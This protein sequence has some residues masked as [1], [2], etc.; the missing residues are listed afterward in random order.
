MRT[1]PGAAPTTRS[2]RVW[3]A[4]TRAFH[5][6]LAA[7]F[8]GAWLLSE[9]ERFRNLHIGFGYARV[10]LIAWRIVWGFVGTGHARFS[11]FVS[12]PRTILDYVRGLLRGTPRHYV[13]HNPLGAVAILAILGLAIATAATG[14][15]TYN[16]IGGR[17]S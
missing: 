5:W 6:L 9:R 12:G 4:P 16:E 11:D 7:S 3:D 2:I 1:E 17:A 8:A 15:L 13:G 10:A 14:W